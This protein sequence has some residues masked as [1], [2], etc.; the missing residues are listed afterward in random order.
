M[1]RI[2][3]D[4]AEQNF[5]LKISF[6]KHPDY[7][8]YQSTDKK[9]SVW[10][11]DLYNQSLEE[12]HADKEL[13]ISE[14]DIIEPEKI[15]REDAKL[16]HTDEYIKEI[17]GNPKNTTT[18][19]AGGNWNKKAQ[20]AVLRSSGG[21]I[22]NN[23]EALKRGISVQLYDAFHHAYPSH[24]E[25]FCVLNDVAIA[26]TKIAK[27]NKK[28]MIIDTDVHQGNGTA[29]CVANNS[30][31]FTISFHQEYL[32]PIPKEES[33]ID[34]GYKRFMD[35]K[36]FMRKLKS[37]LKEAYSYFQPDLVMFISG[38]DLYKGDTLSETNISI[39][40][41]SKINKYVLD[42]FGEKRIP[43]AISV[44][45]GYAKNLEDTK[46]LIKNVLKQAAL[47]QKQYFKESALKFQSDLYHNKLFTVVPK[48]YDFRVDITPD[49]QNFS[50][51][52]VFLWDT[53]NELK[54]FNA[55][56]W[57]IL[58]VYLP[59]GTKFQELGKVG[60]TAYSLPKIPKEWPMK[61]TSSRP[62]FVQ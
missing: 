10:K 37:T 55:N 30:N 42:F 9:N 52:Y 57:K 33:N 43:I 14:Y 47:S 50:D 24:G 41:I 39:E 60:T 59:K 1:Y 16:I 15:S 62:E 53:W 6:I 8:N 2:E 29:V 35:D 36:E 20:N 27:Q 49:L 11:T 45:Q 32:Y 48:L 4:S 34:V 40:G 19:W 18:A 3:K 22:R 56:K 51:K 58:E 23:E 13:L 38:T 25:G 26:A 28:V 17:F 46:M 44:P 54:S 12:L 5:F 31:I 61:E 21:M 7:Y